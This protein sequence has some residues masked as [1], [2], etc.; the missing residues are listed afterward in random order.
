M[1]AKIQN[2]AEMIWSVR[3]MKLTG[4]CQITQGERGPRVILSTINPSGGAKDKNVFSGQLR[5]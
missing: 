5:R 3:R 1:N 4:K 2:L